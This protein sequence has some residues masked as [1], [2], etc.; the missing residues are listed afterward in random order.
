MRERGSIKCAFLALEPRG[1]IRRLLEVPLREKCFGVSRGIWVPGLLLVGHAAGRMSASLSQ[2][3]PL[4]KEVNNCLL[5]RVVRRPHG[6]TSPEV[7]GY[8]T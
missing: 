1:R 5:H 8:F 4:S 2:S 3:P 6:V 7:S